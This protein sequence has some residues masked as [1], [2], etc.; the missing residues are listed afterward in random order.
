MQFL[1]FSEAENQDDFHSMQ[2]GCVHTQDQF[3][4][5]VM[6]D[7]ALQDL[8]ELESELLLIASHYIE[9]EKSKEADKRK[10]NQLARVGNEAQ[11]QSTWLL[12]TG[13]L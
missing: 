6:Y 7:S 12:W 4:L 11:E 9:K 3:G 13:L 10:K 8:E 2:A 5:Y 1:E